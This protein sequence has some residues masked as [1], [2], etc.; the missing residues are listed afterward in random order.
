MENA[1]RLLGEITKKLESLKLEDTT[2]AREALLKKIQELQTCI[3]VPRKV[4]N[5][6]GEY[7][8]NFII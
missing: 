6:S 5:S 4:E 2:E 3:I 7:M 8:L 1:E